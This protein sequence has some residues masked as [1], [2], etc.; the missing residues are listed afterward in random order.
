MGYNVQIYLGA[1]SGLGFSYLFSDKVFAAEGGHVRFSIENE[2]ELEFAQF[3]KNK[4]NSPHHLSNDRVISG[5][6][7]R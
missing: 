2:F 6:G 4:V 1:G 5:A 7:I 3:Y